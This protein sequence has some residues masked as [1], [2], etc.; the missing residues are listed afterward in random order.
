MS[1]KMVDPEL[2]RDFRG[3]FKGEREALSETFSGV[4]RV[5]LRGSP[6]EI[7]SL[8]KRLREAPDDEGREQEELAE[9]EARNRLRVFARYRE[10]ERRSFPGSVL[11]GRL[12]VSRQRLGQLRVEKKLLGLRLPIHREVYYP[13]WQFDEEGGPLEAMPRLIAAAEDS[14]LG[15]L[16]LDALMTNSGAVD[17][18]VGQVAAGQEGTTPAGLLHSDAP[19]AEEYVISLVRTSLSG[20]S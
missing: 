2:E 4:A 18:E 15:A 20:A 13:A 7:L 17:A 11:Q 8:E 1:Q 19:E 16:A 14:G 5:L 6:E 9:L 3:R 10:V 12:G